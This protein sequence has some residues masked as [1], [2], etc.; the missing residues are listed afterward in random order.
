MIQSGKAKGK[1]AKLLYEVSGIFRLLK[2]TS[3]GS[4]S[5]QRYVKPLSLEVKYMVE[6]HLL[7]SSKVLP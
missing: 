5:V 1:V 4:N 6:D 7:L 2:F 3:Q